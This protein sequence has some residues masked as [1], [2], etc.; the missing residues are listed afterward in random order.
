MRF[1]LA[2]LENICQ[3]NSL[4]LL[5]GNVTN[6]LY[7]EKFMHKAWPHMVKL[8]SPGNKEEI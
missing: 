2:L 4:E 1:T 3:E 6:G 8:H 7:V 5:Q